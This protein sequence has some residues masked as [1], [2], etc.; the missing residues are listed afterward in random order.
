MTA[1][2]RQQT[3]RNILVITCYNLS[4]KCEQLWDK[5]MNIQ[6]PFSPKI[7]KK[8]SY[9]CDV[10]IMYQ[11]PR[12]YVDCKTL[13]FPNKFLY[14]LNPFSCVKQVPNVLLR[15][16]KSL[17]NY[18]ILLLQHTRNIKRVKLLVLLKTSRF[19]CLLLRWTSNV[20]NEF[21]VH[22]PVIQ[23]WIRSSSERT[24]TV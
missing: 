20:G 6:L 4:M 14:F 19:T 5:L 9:N 1:P 3:T 12:I 24:T 23:K 13:L 8:G 7:W 15:K 22:A 2:S 17:R 16:G 18:T 10:R 11:L 21:I